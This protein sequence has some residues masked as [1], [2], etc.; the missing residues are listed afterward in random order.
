MSLGRHAYRHSSHQL[1]D[2]TAE[3]GKKAVYIAGSF[4][5]VALDVDIQ[6]R[7]AF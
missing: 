4:E 5:I 3:Q 1:Q 2:H 6:S 7:S